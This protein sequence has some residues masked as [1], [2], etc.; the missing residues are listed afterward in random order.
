MCKPLDSF[1]G[2][3][4]APQ[5]SHAELVQYSHTP[6]PSLSV[7]FDNDNFLGGF[8]GKWVPAYDQLSNAEEIVFHIITKETNNEDDNIEETLPR[9]IK[10][11]R[12][13]SIAKAKLTPVSNKGYL[14]IDKNLERFYEFTEITKTPFQIYDKGLLVYDSIKNYN[15]NVK[16]LLKALHIGNRI[17]AYNGLKIVPKS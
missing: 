5:A 2:E 14:Y 17:Y 13:E 16:F 15:K 11:V 7:P 1:L 9:D 10:H 3:D 8:K 12:T 6:A 4:D